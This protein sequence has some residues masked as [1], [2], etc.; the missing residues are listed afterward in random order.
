MRKERNAAAKARSILSRVENAG[1]FTLDD[2]LAVD[3]LAQRLSEVGFETDP[4]AAARMR[5]AMR[6]A[7]QQQCAAIARMP[8]DRIDPKSMSFLRYDLSAVSDTF[9]IAT[10]FGAFC[11][12]IAERFSIRTHRDAHDVDLGQHHAVRK[13]SVPM[14][15]TKAV[16]SAEAIREGA[17]EREDH[18]TVLE[19][20]N[21]TVGFDDEDLMSERSGGALLSACSKM[22][23]EN[24]ATYRPPDEYLDRVREE[25][26]PCSLPAEETSNQPGNPNP[27]R[28][29][30]LSALP[31]NIANQDDGVAV[32]DAKMMRAE[33]PLVTAE[34][35]VKAA[36]RPLAA[37]LKEKVEESSDSDDFPFEE[38]AESGLWTPHVGSSI[39]RTQGCPHP[40]FSGVGVRRFDPPRG[41]GPRRLENGYLWTLNPV[42]NLWRDNTASEQKTRANSLSLGYSLGFDS[43]EGPPIYPALPPSQFGCGGPG[44]DLHSL[45]DLAAGV[46]LSAP[47][48]AFV[49]DAGMEMTNLHHIVQARPFT[50]VEVESLAT[51]NYLDVLDAHIPGALA[52]TRPYLLLKSKIDPAFEQDLADAFPIAESI[53]RQ[54]AVCGTDELPEEDAGSAGYPTYAASARRL[55]TR[56]RM[57]RDA[58]HDLLGVDEDIL[59]AMSGRNLVFSGPA[60]CGKTHLLK[61]IVSALTA[62]PDSRNPI[63][64][65]LVNL[66]T[67]VK[68]LLLKSSTPLVSIRCLNILEMDK[69]YEELKV[70]NIDSKSIKILILDEYSET[71]VVFLEKIAYFHQVIFF[72]DYAQDA[73]FHWPI[74]DF[75][76][77]CG[78]CSVV[79]ETVWRARLSP[80]FDVT[81]LLAYGGAYR[82]SMGP[83]DV[84]GLTKRDPI[85]VL[86]CID[87]PQAEIFAMWCAAL[88]HTNDNR[89]VTIVVDGKEAWAAADALV[90]ESSNNQPAPTLLSSSELR[91]HECDVLLF[92]ATALD[93]QVNLSLAELFGRIIVLFGRPKLQIE[94]VIAESSVHI[95]SSMRRCSCLLQPLLA[96]RIAPSALVASRHTDLAQALSAEN[97]ELVEAD[98]LLL[99]VRLPHHRCLLLIEGVP[100]NP[101]VASR[102]RSFVAS[103]DPKLLNVPSA[104]LPADPRFKILLEQLARSDKPGGA[105]E[106][107][108]RSSEILRPNR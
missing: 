97:F 16:V 91:G 72:G 84:P 73:C 70:D 53:V 89:R 4:D 49:F 86:R 96:C 47:Y 2:L 102:W 79:L 48:R 14:A 36:F 61:K 12:V 17:S 33:P 77:R 98:G 50:A 11:D 106:A 18:T 26:P 34:L 76:K 85:R 103:V 40:H 38:S 37:R 1:A 101:A 22:A 93:R 94:I 7:V 32:S 41:T 88:L 69:A 99:A 42:D 71:S 75:I 67:E 74:F 44:R 3:D 9:T 35:S 87:D 65:F 81:S 6:E 29:F 27:A 20:K 54:V 21:S 60:G 10:L 78:G 80:L 68:Q 55:G 51:R 5:D 83:Y 59:L 13:N 24:E 46:L 25:L 28:V 39:I 57:R 23:P 62:K 31:A 56:N 63:E 95:S 105:A 8:V 82:V 19:E 107:L 15:V 30:S 104:E 66:R 92:S 58:K 52:Q 108:L 90:R 100:P 64:L 45:R 43:G